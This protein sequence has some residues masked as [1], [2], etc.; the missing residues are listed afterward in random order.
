[1][2]RRPLFRLAYRGGKVAKAFATAGGAVK[3]KPP[4]PFTEGE[5]DHEV[6]EGEVLTFYLTITASVYGLSVAASHK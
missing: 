5:G 6:V 4:L 1:M 3:E 2:T